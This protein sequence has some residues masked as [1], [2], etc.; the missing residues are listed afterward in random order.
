MEQEKRAGLLALRVTRHAIGDWSRGQGGHRE[1]GDETA[2]AAAAE[3]I[4]KTNS[5]TSATDLPTDDRGRQ[6]EPLTDDVC[7]SFGF[8]N[9]SLH[10]AL[11][12]M[13]EISFNALSHEKPLSL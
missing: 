5:P 10:K 11:V 7:T 9:P 4:S 3:V 6:R 12:L 2:A 8:W 1:S 13:H